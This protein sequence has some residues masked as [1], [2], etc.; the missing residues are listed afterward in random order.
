MYTEA[1][2]SVSAYSAVGHAPAHQEPL[3]S[4]RKPTDSMDSGSALF[5]G[6]I[7]SAV[8]F[9]DDALDLIVEDVEFV[10]QS[11]QPFDQRLDLF[12]EVLLG[13]VRHCRLL[14]WRLSLILVVVQ[15]KAIARCNG[16]E[17]NTDWAE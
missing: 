3:G 2:R 6:L 11:R 13:Q 15:R 4:R 1:A 9:L 5:V 12:D 10:A 16:D 7:E 17:R 14:F 8:D